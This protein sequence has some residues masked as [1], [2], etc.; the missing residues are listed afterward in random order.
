VM[1]H[2]AITLTLDTYGHLIEGAEAQAVN[3]NADLTSVASVIA[4]T[5]GETP[6]AAATGT[7]SAKSDPP[8]CAR[9]APEFG[10][11]GRID[12]NNGERKAGPKPAV[13]RSSETTKTPRFPVSNDGP[14]TTANR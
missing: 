2:S 14:R 11:L 1:R 6:V 12:A 10:V 4:A 7:D 8:R 9:I 5:A 13:S 3:A